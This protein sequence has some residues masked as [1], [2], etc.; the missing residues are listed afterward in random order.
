MRLR[1]LAMVAAG[2]L[3]G[4]AAISLIDSL[5]AVQAT[6][7]IEAALAALPHAHAASVTLD[8]W[9]GRIAIAGLSVRH[10]ASRLHIGKI[11]LDAVTAPSALIAPAL[12]RTGSA[13]AEDVE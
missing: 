13:E 12:A 11:T 2:L 8:P 4:G 7:R 9:S 6:R 10:G 5:A 1:C 3:A